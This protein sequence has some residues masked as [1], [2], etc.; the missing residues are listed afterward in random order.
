M[1]LNV[2]SLFL[3]WPE[4]RVGTDFETEEEPGSVDRFP[5]EHLFLPDIAQP[6]EYV[7]LSSFGVENPVFADAEPEILL[8]LQDEVSPLA[9]TAD[10]F[11]DD[12]G[13]PFPPDVV[14]L[15]L[16]V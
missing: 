5:S 6:A 14:H 7:E 8:T 3:G 10:D 16:A 1:N 11:N 13:N 2:R 15:G 4:E 9:P 12:I